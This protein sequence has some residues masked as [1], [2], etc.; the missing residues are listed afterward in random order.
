MSEMISQARER[1][2]RIRGMAQEKNTL[3]SALWDATPEKGSNAGAAKLAEATRKRL[4][5]GELIAA[6]NCRNEPRA[7]WARDEEE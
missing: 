6:G 1:F 4:E 7:Y 5:A 2:D 3:L